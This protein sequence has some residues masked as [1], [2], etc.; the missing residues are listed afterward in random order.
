MIH[1]IVDQRYNGEVSGIMIGQRREWNMSHVCV[2]SL[3]LLENCIM[4]WRRRTLLSWEVSVCKAVNA[5]SIEW[6]V[7]WNRFRACY[8]P[9]KWTLRG[10]GDGRSLICSCWDSLLIHLCEKYKPVNYGLSS[11]ELGSL[12][13]L[14]RRLIPSWLLSIDSRKDRLARSYSECFFFFFFDSYTRD[15]RD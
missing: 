8:R 12:L 9:W 11:K 13:I 1:E 5:V 3:N 14:A 4:K 7:K 2:R 15:K 6:W 10:L